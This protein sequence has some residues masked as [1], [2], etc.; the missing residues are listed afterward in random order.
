MN[1]FKGKPHYFQFALLFFINL[2]FLYIL[3]MKKSLAP[4]RRDNKPTG[5]ANALAKKIPVKISE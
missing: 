5:G 4:P 3:S 1:L 2:T